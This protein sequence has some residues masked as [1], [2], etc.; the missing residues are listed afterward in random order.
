MG[1]VICIV[2]FGAGT[3]SAQ[4]LV[5]LDGAIQ[6]AVEGFTYSL[7]RGSKIA[8]LS[9]RTGSTRMSN[10]LTEELIY[11]IESRQMFTVADKVVVGL[12][13]EEMNLQMYGDISDSSARA[14]GRRLG[15][16]YVVTGT[17]DYVGNYHRFRVRVLDVELDVIRVTY[18]TNV[19]NDEVVESLLEG[20]TRV[21]V[22]TPTPW[23]YEDFNPNERWGTFVLNWLVPG[24]GSYI[25]MKDRAGCVVQVLVGGTGVI[26]SAVGI[27]ELINAYDNEEALSA[28]IPISIGAGL[29]FGNFVYNIIR[30][31]T[32][33]KPRPHT[34]SLIDPTA[35]NIEVQ[36]GKDGIEQVS[37]SYTLRF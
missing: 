15:A 37:L 2:I 29:V 19:R 21:S 27:I 26:F 36:P 11:A 30:S 5:T 23:D 1:L 10:Y 3:V 4:A 20:E 24:L 12:M 6:G 13:L 34:A 18:S 31:S 14:I 9:M 8:F 32:Y 22:F 16:Q 7:L 35:W 17:M 25:I 28:T 33:K